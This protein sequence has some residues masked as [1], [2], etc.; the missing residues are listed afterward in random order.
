M[1]ARTPGPSD[2]PIV[3][4]GD[5]SRWRLAG[6]YTLLL[7]ALAAWLGFA[8]LGANALTNEESQY[9][10]CV[11]NVVR[12]GDWISISPYP[13]A[14]YFQKPPL[15]IWLNAATYGWF[16][17][18]EGRYRIGSAAFGVGCVGLTCLLGAAMFSAEVGLLAGL[19]LASNKSFLMH[20][21]MRSG[22]F[23]VL[24]TFLVLAC[25]G[26]YWLT[27]RRPRG[28]LG[29]WIGLGVLAG[30]ACLT[31]P[32]AGLPVLA[33]LA[34]HALF[35]NRSRPRRRRLASVALALGVCLAVAAPWYLALYARY[36]HQF[37]HEMFGRNL[38]E[39]AT[40]GLDPAHLRPAWYYLS[41]LSGASVPFW[42]FIPALII[43]G[44]AA[45][46][47][48]RYRGACQVLVV[49]SAGWLLI[50]SLSVSKAQHYAYPVFPLIAIAIAASFTW[51]L[52]AL[53]TLL[54][55]HEGRRWVLP[56]AH[57]ITVA[58]FAL[59]IGLLGLRFMNE[60]ARLYAPWETYQAFHRRYPGGVRLVLYRFPPRQVQWREQLGL[61]AQDCFYIEQ[62]EPR[63]IVAEAGRVAEAAPAL[64]LAPP[65]A[66][67]PPQWRVVRR[68]DTFTMAQVEAE[69]N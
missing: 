34:A 42:F 68:H 15:Y 43:C 12:S 1:M 66:L 50:F 16:T 67:L 40:V 19:V 22:T 56:T 48:P 6:F 9:A 60:P 69:S 27:L 10:L 25:V 26:L 41:S 3:A 28:E 64:V 4:D 21:G 62:M 5:P 13:P 29:L 35:L 31:K 17:D 44:V 51:G 55:D 39:R 46:R 45:V 32:L 49:V 47:E 36:P 38:I 8:R 53:G 18:M 30:L 14:P 59:A 20:H 54:G 65:Q 37:L 61:N 58:V 63:R 52:M 23:D 11:Q 57:G 33:C 2:D 24:L 7:M